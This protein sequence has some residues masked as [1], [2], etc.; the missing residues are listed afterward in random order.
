MKLNV[1]AAALLL[2]LGGCGVV[3]HSPSIDSF[4]DGPVKVRVAPVTPDNVLIAN[5]SGYTPRQ[6]P[7][8]FFQTAGSVSAIRQAGADLPDPVYDP[9]AKPAALESRLPPAAVSRPYAIGVSDVLLLATPQVGST[10]EQ[11]TG[12]LAAQN[13]R[14]GYTVQD[15]GAIA[16]PN[17]GRVQVAGLTVEEAEA[18]LFQRLVEAQIDPTFSLEIAEF[19]SKKVSI[20]GAVAAPTIAPV[21]LSPL[22]LDEALA[23]AGGI[24]VADQDYASVRI[25]RDGTLYQIPLTELYSRTGLNRILL[26][27]GDSIFVDTEY[28]LE[29]AQAFFEQQI[30]LTNF[31]QTSRTQALNEL[32]AE[33]TVRRTALED[34]RQNFL[35][36]LE[37]GA[38]KRDY[39][40][41]AGEVT[42]QGRVPMPFGQKAS[43]AD[44]L[45]ENGG[46]PLATADARKLYVLRGSPDPRD[47]GALTAWQLDTTDAANLMLATRF[48]M[49]PNDVIFAAEQPITKWNR[50]IQQIVPSLLNTTVSAVQ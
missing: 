48:E 19:N 32:Q 21:T 35:T 31:S 50:V 23:A 4:S 42:K 9:E 17:V 45:Y 44:M 36:R 41:L 34:A 40:Y 18:E 16:I 27:D 5:Q 7:A 33:F 3:Y 10:I 39:V 24:T 22:Y 37:L 8:A 1:I 12:L 20:G 14:Q 49:R 38:E 43:L 30:A 25:Y 26:Q 6:L 13:S 28:E 11:L 15:D 29:L 2:S 46:T 47:F